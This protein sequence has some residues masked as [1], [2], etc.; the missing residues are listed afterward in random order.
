MT[1]YGPPFP[2]GGPDYSDSGFRKSITF[3]QSPSLGASFIAMTL[4]SLIIFATNTL[5]TS[6][7]LATIGII[8]TL[9]VLAF[10]GLILVILFSL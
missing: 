2:S 8:V 4:F 6:A 9:S 3:L 1:N 7:N 5:F 10:T